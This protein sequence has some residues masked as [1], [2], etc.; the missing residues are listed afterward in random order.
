MAARATPLT[1]ASTNGPAGAQ[2]APMPPTDA[3]A[4]APKKGGRAKVVF[5]ALVAL[6]AIGGG[7]TYVSNIGRETTD[8]AQIEG[9][10]GNVAARVAGQVVRVVVKDN[11]TVQAGDVLLEL[12]DRDYQIRL[13]A[14]KADLEAARAGLRSAETQL[15]V[16][17]KSVES[18]L[19]VAKG[20]LGQA[21]GLAGATRAGIDQAHA[22]VTAAESRRSLA[23]TEL[24]RSQKL[25]ADRAVSKAELDARQTALE[26]QDAQLA[27][28]RARLASAEAGNA[29]SSGTYESA[30][31]KLIAAQAGP[32][33]VEAA[34]AQVSLAKAKVEQAEAAHAQ[35]E[36]NL[37]YTKVRALLGGVIARRT[38]EPG[39]LVSPERPL[40]AIVPL[41]DTWVVANFKEDQLARMHPGQSAKVKIDTYGGKIIMGKVES[42][43]GGTGS[44]FS[45]LPPDNASGNFTKVVQRVPVIIT[46]DA[47]PDLVLR[48]GMSTTVTVVTK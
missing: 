12:D 46:L 40:M 36:L 44:R 34:R 10:I 33:Q 25:F 27:Q 15:A 29:N 9:H 26:Q 3:T 22:D 8:D 20:G 13:S 24:E 2:T 18:N 7:V 42:L 39:Q 37:Q 43:S 41:D 19:V 11:Q 17:E 47:H 38:V 16:T 32:E 28:A 1:E 35:A 5:G 6:A 14:A 23:R 30:R 4:T 31:G 48:P 45:L 21:A